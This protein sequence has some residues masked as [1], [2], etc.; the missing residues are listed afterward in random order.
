MAM[1][2]LGL[3]RSNSDNIRATQT[4]GGDIPDGEG[5]RAATRPGA[6]YEHTP[7]PEAY[8]YQTLSRPPQANARSRGISSGSNNPAARS[9]A[10]VLRD[11]EQQEQERLT[12]N[13]QAG[14]PGGRP[15][16][17]SEDVDLEAV[18]RLSAEGGASDSEAARFLEEQRAAMERFEANQRAP[19]TS[20]SSFPENDDHNFASNEYPSSTDGINTEMTTAGGGPNRPLIEI[21]PG[22]FGKWYFGD[23]VHFSTF[24]YIH[25]I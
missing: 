12:Q 15:R 9:R 14:N 20:S 22:R 6:V 25:D 21:S 24:F 5:R 19:T 10:D 7:A 17:L 4:E 16:A 11:M 2:A 23:R 8:H 18:L 13:S 3:D 1:E